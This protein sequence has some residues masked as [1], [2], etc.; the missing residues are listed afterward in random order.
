MWLRLGSS[1]GR[2]LMVQ[3]QRTAVSHTTCTCMYMS[4]GS[5]PSN[6]KIGG[7]KGQTMAL[8]EKMRDK[9]DRDSTLHQGD[10][11][12]EL[13]QEGV[14]PWDL[15]QPT[16]VLQQELDTTALTSTS[17][18]SSVGKR[19]LVPG[20]GSGFDLITLAERLGQDSVIVGL[21]IST[22]SL[23]RAQ[24]VL[25][26]HHSSSNT[27]ST[28]TVLLAQGDFFE[29]PDSWDTVFS[30]NKDDPSKS[31]T[32]IPSFGSSFDL[33][34]DY[35]FFC[36]LP[37]S[38]RPQWGATM[39]SLL[40]PSQG[41]LLTLMFPILPDADPTRGPP[42]PVTVQDYQHVLQCHGVV[43]ES[44]E[45]YASTQTVPSRVGKEL[46]CWWKHSSTVSAAAGEEDHV[47]TPVSKL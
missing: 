19:V 7:K 47:P 36:A 27:T 11:W 28:G 40:E 26:D 41:R 15:H 17:T 42:F 10:S 38:L 34:Y 1:V 6:G 37:L 23:Q 12:E 16:P 21:D 39:A 20:C 14:T 29:R 5:G 43:M 22:T 46:V 25:L 8:V 45:P 18:S 4:D 13:W 31:N 44:T 33:I 24:Q 35:V 2:R 3:R 30:T 32:C 9:L